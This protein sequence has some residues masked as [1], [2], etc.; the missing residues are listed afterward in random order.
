MTHR[1]FT[2]VVSV[3]FRVMFGAEFRFVAGVGPGR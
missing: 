2:D 3:T 1:V